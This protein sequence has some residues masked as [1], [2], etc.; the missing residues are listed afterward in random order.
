[1]NR[2]S[3]DNFWHMDMLKEPLANLMDRGVTKQKK[4]E[5]EHNL[6]GLLKGSDVEDE[7]MTG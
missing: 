1:M 5:D 6:Y 2:Y 3:G 7:E 4:F